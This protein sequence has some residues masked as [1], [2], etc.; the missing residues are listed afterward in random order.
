MSGTTAP[1]SLAD[2]VVPRTPGRAA[3]P[4]RRP[5][6]RRGTYLRMS[7]TDDVAISDTM[8]TLRSR[9]LDHP[10]TSRQ[11][12]S[13]ATHAP[14]HLRVRPG[15]GGDRRPRGRRVR[16]AAPTSLDELWRSYKATGDAAAARAVDPALLA[17]GEVR[18]GP[19]QRGAAGQRRAGGLR[20]LRGVRADR[21]DRE[22]RPRARDQV[23]D[24]R[25]HPD[26]RRHDRRTA[27]PGLDPALG[28]AEGPRGR[29]R[30]RHAG[31]ASSAAPPRE[32]EV[33]AEMGIGAGGP[34][35]ASSASS[36]WPTWSRWRSCCTSAA[37]AA[38]GSAWSTP[39]RTPAPTTRSRSP[40]TANCAGCSPAPSTPSPSG[41][42]P[43]SP[44]TT[45][46]A[47]PSP[48]SA[49]YWASPRA[50]SAR[51][52]PSPCSSCGQSSPTSAG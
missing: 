37:R 12:G 2:G 47:S 40:R 46:R 24:L 30:L 49:R 17:A 29:A 10:L 32:P 35:R 50:G 22:V 3:P 27:G 16:P 45:T 20:L 31:G 8:V 52:T 5:R 18:G 11:N 21:R 6:T 51:S 44:S 26:P 15:D 39:W 48:R 23:R 9:R 42:R 43:S 41:R 13:Q 34:A 19:G 1:P 33:A 36:P 4:V 38:T 28:P 7:H 25:D 14:A